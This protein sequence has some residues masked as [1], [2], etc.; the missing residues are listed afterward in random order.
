VLL[1]A[2]LKVLP[3]RPTL[4]TLGLLVVPWIL[5]W[6]ILGMW[7]WADCGTDGCRDQ[8]T[9][10]IAWPSLMPVSLWIA[11]AYAQPWRRRRLEMHDAGD[12]QGRALSNSQ[13]GE[14]A[15]ERFR[16]ARRA[17]CPESE[18][19]V[20]LRAAAGFYH[21]RAGRFAD[22]R[23]YAHAALRN[24]ETFGDRV[25]ADIRRCSALIEQ[26]ERDLQSQRG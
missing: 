17:R 6:D 8:M 18:Q 12:G 25:A 13:R 19:R 16:E 21:A 11:A 7:G 15:H 20:H 24:L 3:L 23:E 14:V 4:I 2:V 22:A 5:F 1:L 26:I 10:H 9:L